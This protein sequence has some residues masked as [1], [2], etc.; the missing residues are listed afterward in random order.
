V[1]FFENLFDPFADA[2]GPPPTTLIAFGKWLFAGAGKAVVMM[3]AVSILIGLAEV[4]AAWAVGVIIDRINTHG[5]E[6][7][8]DG[9]IWP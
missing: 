4:A 9:F 5:R 2:N 6:V 8:L 3:G 7:F 1:K